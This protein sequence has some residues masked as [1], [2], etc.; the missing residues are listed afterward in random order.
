MKKRS[1]HC[2][3]KSNRK[4]C[5]IDSHLQTQMSAETIVTIVL[6]TQSALTP[7]VHLNA[8]VKEG[9]LRLV[10]AALVCI[11]EILSAM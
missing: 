6:Q 5:V 2:L 9:T 1:L 8:T 3:S 11:T 7:G 10:K 4:K